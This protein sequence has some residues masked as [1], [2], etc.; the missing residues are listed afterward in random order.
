[1]DCS[2]SAQA[3]AASSS[4][5]L[6]PYSI[7]CSAANSP[8]S[9]DFTKPASRTRWAR[10]NTSW[11]L[12]RS[13]AHEIAPSMAPRWP[14]AHARERK[15]STTSSTT[16]PRQA[17]ID[18]N[19]LRTKSSLRS[20]VAF[21][22]ARCFRY[23]ARWHFRKRRLS[24]YDQITGGR[25]SAGESGGTLGTPPGLPPRQRS[26]GRCGPQVTG[27]PAPQRRRRELDAQRVPSRR[28][29]RRCTGH[30]V[31]EAQK[32]TACVSCHSPVG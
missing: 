17:L 29:R 27:G 16:A 28:C 12:N 13:L 22:L 1:M 6:P 3:D 19:W 14:P 2:T 15:C 10:A 24:E 20:S 32:G 30:R 11:A 9:L 18:C 23:Q 7:Q 26:R 8:G 25:P 21:E 5:T 31:C 4:V